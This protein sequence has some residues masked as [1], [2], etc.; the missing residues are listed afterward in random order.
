MS[1]QP[2]QGTER[3]VPGDLLTPSLSAA[4]STTLRERP[5]RVNSQLWIAFLAGV[6]PVTVVALINARRLG[7]RPA[8]I[9]LILAI[10]LGTFLISLLWLAWQAEAAASLRSLSQPVN[11]APLR[12][13]TRVLAVLAYLAMA[14]IQRP[15][16]R[17]YRLFYGDTYASLWRPGLII[18]LGGGLVQAGIQAMVL[19]LVLA[20]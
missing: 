12:L 13:G 3:S 5:W 16:E 1:D 2:S 7:L 4:P 19:A 17:R 18:C 8:A 11:R 20:R 9:R 15:A 14:R 6:L 10:G